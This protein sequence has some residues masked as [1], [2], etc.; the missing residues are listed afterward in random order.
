[1]TDLERDQPGAWRIR[2][3]ERRDTLAWEAMRGQ[4]WPAAPG[5]HAAEIER[6]FAGA[7]HEPA[8]VLVAVDQDDQPI[9][10]AELSIRSHADGCE[11]EGVGYLEGWFVQEAYRRRGAG[12]AL[13]RAAEQ[14]ARGQGCSE[15]ASDVELHNEVSLAAH[16]FLG[17]EE[18]SR[19]VTFRKQL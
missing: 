19:V 7:R 12:T 11:S 14:W 15:F 4:L 18:V 13:V 5:E 6:F 16:R 17:F 9:G 10:F 3:V 8:E 2:P 1:M